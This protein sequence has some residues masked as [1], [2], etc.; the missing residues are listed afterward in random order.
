MPL[1]QLIDALSGE[2]KMATKKHVKAKSKLQPQTM[3]V[4]IRV[5]PSSET[6]T[7]YV[8]H[9]EVAHNQHEFALFTGKLPAKL[10]T[11]ELEKSKNSGVLTLDPSLQILLPPSIIRGLL[12]ALQMQLDLYEKNFGKIV[13]TSAGVNRGDKK[14]G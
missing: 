3:A 12:R 8:N 2:Q 5:E 7:Y 9:V 1:R 4:Q 10:S 6:P 11:E 14:V 13:D